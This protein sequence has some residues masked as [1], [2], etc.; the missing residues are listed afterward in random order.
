[1]SV[2]ATWDL[3]AKASPR[4]LAV[5]P[6]VPLLRTATTT[7]TTSTNPFDAPQSDPQHTH[8]ISSNNSSS[9]GNNNNVVAVLFGTDRG[10]LHYRSYAAQIASSEVSAAATAIGSS[11][12][13]NRVRRSSEALVP[14]T[15]L[16]QQPLGSARGP[17]RQSPQQLPRHY[18]PMDLGSLP[19]PVV[20]C[21]FIQ[22]SPRAQRKAH[23]QP[24]PQ[25]TFLLL[26]DD[27]RGAA[28][29]QGTYA[30]L[31]VASSVAT[32]GFH[33]VPPPPSPPWGKPAA[34]PLPR[35]S[36]AFYD[37]DHSGQLVYGAGRTVQTLAPE[38]WE[39]PKTAAAAARHSR[40]LAFAALL[41]APGMRGGP[42]ALV[43]TARGK[44][45]VAAVGNAFFAVAGTE[46][47]ETE[48]ATAA[49]GGGGGGNSDARSSSALKILSFQQ[50][51][52]VHPVIVIDLHDRS[53]D[54]DWS[55]LFLASGRE[56][57]VVDLYA[58]ASDL[59]YSNETV[60]NCSK[61]RHGIVTAASPILAAAAS[62]PWV[63][64]LQSDGLI[65][66]RSPS[67]LAIPLRTV[68]V[69]Q[70]PN[71]YFVLRAASP[72]SS[73]DAAAPY[74][75]AAA[76]SGEC[77]V[78][79]CQPD[80][81][82]DLAD[83][84]MRHAIDA[85]G[86]SGFPRAELAE[87][88]SA[89]FTATSY[90][91]PE[92]SPTS[93]SLL[94]QYLEAVLGLADF[95][96]GGSS[97]WPTE[98]SE[99]DVH[100]G[101]F[102]G[103]GTDR[104]ASFSGRGAAPTVVSSA[105]PAVLLNGTALLC[106]VCSQVTPPNSFLASRAAKACTEKIGM[107]F[108]GTTGPL[109]EAA[110]RVCV[111]VAEKLLREAASKFTLLAGSSPSP[112]ARVHRS[113]QSNTVT[114]FIEAATWLLRSCGKHARAIEV[115]YERLQQQGQQPAS[116]GTG[117]IVRGFWSQI[118]YESYTATHLS[119]IWGAGV[120]EGC[121]LVLT[122]PATHRLL[123]SNPRLGLSVFTAMHP[124][125]ESQ[126]RSLPA[127]DD[128][129]AHP[130]RVY[131]VLKLLKSIKPTIPYD[132][133][134]SFTQDEDVTLP[135]ES[136]RAVA[137]SFLR[138]AIGIATGRPL[139]DDDEYDC[140]PVDADFEEH[141][142]NFHDELS[143]LLL[144]GVIVERPDDE[145]ETGDTELGEIYRSMLRELLKWPLA[146]IRPENFTDALP[147]TFLEEKALMLGRVGRHD[148]ALRIL[149]GDLNSLDLALAYCDDRY[150]RQSVHNEQRRSRQTQHHTL[151]YADS[152]P[153]ADDE[154]KGDGDTNNNNA[155]IPLIRVALASGDT[156]RGTA[157]AI[158]VLALR[159]GAVDRAAALRLLPA[160]VPVSAVARPF[161]IPALLDSASH[162]RRLTVV[163]A[164]LR[165]RYVRLRE[166]HTAA[167]LRA[168]AHLHVVP[169]L[170]GLR[171][172]DPLHSTKATRART[173]SAT[174]HGPL[175]YLELVKHFFPRHLV[176]QARVTNI[177]YAS[178][179]SA[180]SAAVYAASDRS[181]G[182][183][184]QTVL[185]DIAF[186]VAESSEEE[187][188]QPLL[189]VPIQV[190][191]PKMT[192]SAWCVLSAAPGHMDGPTAL[193]TCELRYSVQSVDA[194]SA[195]ALPSS[196]AVSPTMAAAA[197]AA[198]RT[199]VEELHDL[200]VHAA[201]F[202]PKQQH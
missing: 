145:G 152:D 130:E 96:S 171:L 139:D 42:D 134:R 8:N 89:S 120:D 175:P 150:A 74:I 182:A 140:L 129:L 126:W 35:M 113:A 118:K 52:Q 75:V 158:K 71:D 61:P 133:E 85:F 99:G 184:H 81:S 73:S 1:M 104:R 11:S 65:S 109:S 121:H 200:E 15:N 59:N 29:T 157:T 80:S 142:A 36:C 91:G 148:D 84:L 3:Q 170:R 37:A 165:S 23:Q 156:E 56:C 68:E 63:A 160:D 24:P 110:V 94:K 7:A 125:N 164:L 60:L 194:A 49:S 21:I 108:E 76:Y 199:F 105:S 128:P 33:V 201:H 14:S 144:E 2:E 116:D 90:V 30:S 188:I 48:N 143:L 64:L 32:P 12:S 117:G 169:A 115:S 176:I 62:W 167:Q 178:Y 141:V 46:A 151:Q 9:S 103:G 161:L 193:L 177:P 92:A 132:K 19:G 180:S 34:L 66:I 136:G 100:H 95:E 45:A 98:L 153:A 172:G 43:V 185:S 79:Q 149:Y 47:S 69:G 192:G 25:Q 39:P 70:R 196:H 93:R 112:I 77:K 53:L 166:Q 22:P 174:P 154:G 195:A 31:L 111:L 97:G 122:S 138:S 179:T 197:T 107:V 54:V 82:Q 119:E 88:V 106:L 50:S 124:Q 55:S 5:F 162:A 72:P 4:S 67:C 102:A 123:E 183:H 173:A 168:Q 58:C 190:L 191:P 27:G 78:L 17:T 6:A 155:Y 28:A 57:A 16:V 51:S 13:N 186:V 202:S 10:S 159:R 189:L 83:R 44:V 187:A 146:K 127:R 163:A 137:V 147:S 41:P 86:A 38:Q 114:D 87:A 198:A 131:E 181:V 20:A 18:Y 135:L 26:V 101:T 40:R